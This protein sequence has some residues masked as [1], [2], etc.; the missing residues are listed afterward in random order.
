MAHTSFK[1]VKDRALSTLSATQLIGDPTLTLAAG[2][3]ALFPT[4]AGNTYWITVEGEQELVTGLAGDVLT[5]TRAQNGTSAAEHAAGVAVEIRIVAAQTTAIQTAVNALEDGQG[6]SIQTKTLT[7]V[8]DTIPSSTRTVLL[9]NTSGGVLDLTSIPQVAVGTVDGQRLTI[10]VISAAANT[11]KL[12]TANGLFLSQAA[13]SYTMVQYDT[14]E[15]VWSVS[16]SM[17]LESTRSHNA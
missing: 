8:G 15:L 11:V 4:F 5:T 12:D 16:A 10:I 6:N 1:R 17:W 13:G 3:G 7:V 2:G 14:L 9:D